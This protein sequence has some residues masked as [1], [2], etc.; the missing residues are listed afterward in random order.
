MDLRLIFLAVS[1]QRWNS[2]LAILKS[3]LT[4]I[5]VS[6][7]NVTQSIMALIHWTTSSNMLRMKLLSWV[8]KLCAR[9]QILKER[10]EARVC[11]A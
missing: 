8:S 11:Y 3:L 1:L 7:Q 10:C 6:E 4:L 5:S 9:K 2:A